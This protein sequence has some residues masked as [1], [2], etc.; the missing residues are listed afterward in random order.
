[1]RSSDWSSDVCSSDLLA[2]AR[3]LQPA[4]HHADLGRDQ[5]PVARAAFLQPRAHHAFGLAAL[6]PRN[7][8]R[9][10]V[11]GIDHPAV[12][13]DEAVENS[14]TRGTVG[15]HRSEEQP[16]ELQSLMRNT[17][18]AFCLNKTTLSKRVV[19]T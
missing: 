1:M 3:G 14:E 11:G 7:P 18:A 19:C 12:M 6:V 10:D 15:R 8:R 13:L 16:S 5:D 17:Y 2:D 4:G 9:L